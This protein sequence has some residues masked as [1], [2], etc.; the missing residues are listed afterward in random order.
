MERSLCDV[1]SVL[2]A[3]LSILPYL[4]INSVKC[5]TCCCCCDYDDDDDDDDNDVV[6]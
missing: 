2:R 4:E 3:F 5:L 6:V 1:N